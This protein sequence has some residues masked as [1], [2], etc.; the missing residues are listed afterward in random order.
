M[1]LMYL[2]KSSRSA[3]AFQRV[4]VVGAFWGGGFPLVSLAEHS[5]K[6]NGVYVIFDGGQLSLSGPHLQMASHG[7]AARTLSTVP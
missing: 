6:G 3:R 5:G 1:T 4:Y 7:R 2:Q